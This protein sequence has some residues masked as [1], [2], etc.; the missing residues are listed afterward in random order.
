[1]ETRTWA[2]R[3]SEVEGAAYSII[4]DACSYVAMAD[5]QCSDHPSACRTTMLNLENFKKAISKAFDVIF[6]LQRLCDIGSV[7]SSEQAYKLCRKGEDWRVKEFATRKYKFLDGMLE[8]FTPEFESVEETHGRN[9]RGT[10]TVISRHPRLAI[11]VPIL[12]GLAVGAGVIGTAGITAKVVAEEESSR[13]MNAVRAGRQVDIANNLKNNFI[14]HNFTERLAAELDVIRTT[15][16]ISTHATVLLHDAE[17]LKQELTQLASRKDR[18][19]YSSV[20]AEEYWT[21]IRD[22]NLD[23]DIGLTSSEVNRKT[24]LSAELSTLVTTLSPISNMSTSCS[25]QILTKM[26]LI[27]VIDHRRRTEIE[28]VDNRM[29][30]RNRPLLHEAS[31]Y[32]IIPKDSVMSRETDL[33]GRSSHVIGRICTAS[34]TINATSIPSTE[35]ISETFRLEFTGSIVLNETCRGNEST[36]HT[37]SSPATVT[38]PILCSIQ[39]NEFSCEAVVIRSGDTKL[40]HTTH[41]RTTIIQDHLVKD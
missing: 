40:V 21:A 1:M 16:A 2:Y 38:V 28:L 35:V 41:H 32:F 5:K 10:D 39:S 4:D 22:V 7:P 11:S 33:F 13:V 24:R 31:N 12:I 30:P 19:K 26:L 25:N 37:I 29:I 6:L 14:N 27:P 8:A 36:I 23:N 3:I 17:D 18:L 9:R 20:F 15:E 34:M